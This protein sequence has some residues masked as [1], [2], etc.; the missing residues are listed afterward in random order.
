MKEIVFF[1]DGLYSGH[2]TSYA[3]NL[4]LNTSNGILIIN[5]D[6]RDDFID[7]PNEKKYILN[8]L[9][10]SSYRFQPLGWL[11][12]I[13]H[14][15]FNRKFNTGKMY[16]LYADTIIIYIFLYSL[17]TRNDFYLT[18]HWANA[19]IPIKKINTLIRGSYR[20]LK[21]LIFS[22]LARKAQGIIVH[23]ELSKRL[24][25]SSYNIKVCEIPYGIEEMIS[26]EKLLSK[27][28]ENRSKPNI[29]FFGGI[30]K[31]KG[32]E[33][34]SVLV[35]KSPEY[36]FTIVGK[37]QDYTKEQINKLFDTTNVTLDLRF[38]ADNEIDDIFINS[39]V[40]ILP[41]EYYFSGQSGPLT[42]ST[43]YK[44]PVVGTNVGDM[45]RDISRFNLGITVIDNEPNKMKEALIK[46]IKNKGEY[47][48]SH[49]FYYNRGL[50][51]NVGKQIDRITHEYN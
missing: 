29:L 10:P 48:S 42:L 9:E 11:I 14:L 24:I 7:I 46:V 44:V 17:F 22:Y 35:R 21:F 19:V 30:R 49:D 12:N 45:G 32:I 13:L 39:D 41:Y 20:K 16:F 5:K 23:G 2:H 43:I 33:K 3:K 15:I 47:Y 50:W 51:K 26:R 8:C 38:I 6:R 27:K 40:L 18:I 37:P 4:I 31:D 1:Y 25:E 36:H 34:L 28:R